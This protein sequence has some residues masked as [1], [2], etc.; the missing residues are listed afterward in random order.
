MPLYRVLKKKMSARITESQRLA[1]A[2]EHELQKQLPTMHDGYHNRGVKTAVSQ[3][4][5]GTF[6]P[7]VLIEIGF[8]TNPREA[9][10]LADYR[11]QQLI[12]HSIASGIDHYCRN[13]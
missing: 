9:Q 8:L 12:A 11:Y 10:L 7:T 2:I 6:R 13:I 1:V 3:L 5:L 4:L